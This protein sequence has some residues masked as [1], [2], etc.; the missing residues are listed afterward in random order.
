MALDQPGCI[1]GLL[2]GREIPVEICIGH[3]RLAVHGCD[4]A[5]NGFDE[6]AIA[7][8]LR[9]QLFPMAHQDADL[10]LALEVQQRRDF[11][12]RRA[13]FAM[14]KDPLQPEQFSAAVLAI[15]IRPDLGRCE[16]AD[17]VIMV[18][19]AHRYARNRSNLLDGQI[20]HDAVLRPHDA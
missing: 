17:L 20:L 13:Q 4:R 3:I 9:L 16:Q 8:P 7:F 2:L 11:T 12:K 10:I 5:V 15:T 6:D 1:R 19:R 14:E 18:Q